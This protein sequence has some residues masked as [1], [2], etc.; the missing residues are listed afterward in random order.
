MEQE[1]DDFP[2]EPT[3]ADVATGTSRPA[4]FRPER[5]LVSAAMECG[6]N[7]LIR[8]CLDESLLSLIGP[9]ERANVSFIDY[10]KLELPRCPTPEG[11][12]SNRDPIP[13]AALLRY[14]EY[15]VSEA[16]LDGIRKELRRTDLPPGA[17][18]AT[19]TD[20]LVRK[21]DFSKPISLGTF[22]EEEEDGPVV[23]AAVALA[24]PLDFPVPVYLR[25]LPQVAA[26]LVHHLIKYHGLDTMPAK[27]QLET[28]SVL[29]LAV[30]PL[31]TGNAREV[32]YC[33]A[34]CAP[35]HPRAQFGAPAATPA[36]KAYNDLKRRE[37]SGPEPGAFF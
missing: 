36:S 3:A 27:K 6:Q 8:V 5:M 25:V 18:S 1:E 28:L 30:G 23:V 17:E 7:F 4:R 31:T 2:P 22:Q 14:E 34:L 13:L 15:N 9:R 33:A 37:A 20:V 32:L 26:T 35:E 16:Y 12:R 24:L 21:N 10:A 19:H 11:A 29:R